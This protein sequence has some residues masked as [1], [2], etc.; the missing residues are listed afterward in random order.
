MPP[1]YN[2]PGARRRAHRHARPG[3]E[4]PR[5][6][7]HRRSR[8]PRVE[9]GG[10]LIDPRK[11]ARCGARRPSRPPTCWRCGPIPASGASSSRCRAATWCRSRCRSRTRRCGWRAR[12]ARRSIAPRGP[13]SARWPS[14]SSSPS[15]RRNGCRNTTTSSNPTSACR[16]ATRVNPNIALVTGMSCHQRRAGGDPPRPRWLPLLRLLARLL[17]AVRRAPARA[18]P[19]CGSGSW[20]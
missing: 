16:S 1:R 6:M 19:I 8:R 9:M 15:R 17:R 7:G 11:G 13:A 20:R 4:R 10:F 14:P 18:S 2:H 3:V 5:R 12:S